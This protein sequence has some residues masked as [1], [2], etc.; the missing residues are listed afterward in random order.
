M[1]AKS[2]RNSRESELIPDW[3]FQLFKNLCRK[4]NG[5]ETKSQ[6]EVLPP[7][8]VFNEL[9][10]PELLIRSIRSKLLVNVHVRLFPLFNKFLWEYFTFYISLY[11][12]TFLP[13]LLALF[14]RRL[15]I[16][17]SFLPDYI[18]YMYIYVCLYVYI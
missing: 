15:R 1:F 13:V 9:K 18:L 5:F 16:N 2:L 7:I 8:S 17:F 4:L 6:L 14:L 11:T 10:Q 3:I 12:D